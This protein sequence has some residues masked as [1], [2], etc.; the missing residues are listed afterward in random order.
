[1]N[2]YGTNGCVICTYNI[3]VSFKKKADGME[4]PYPDILLLDLGDKS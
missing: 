2:G 4:A 1:M 3:V